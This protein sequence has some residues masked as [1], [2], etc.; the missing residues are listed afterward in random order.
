M[1]SDEKTAAKARLANARLAK[2]TVRLVVMDSLMASTD[3]HP[4]FV[5]GATAAIMQAMQERGTEWAFRVHAGGTRVAG[6]EAI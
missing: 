2:A 1:E 5:A 6:V 4:E 3:L